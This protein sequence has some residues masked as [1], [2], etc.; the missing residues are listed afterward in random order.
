[1]TYNT[2]G[3]VSYDTFNNELDGYECINDGVVKSYFKKSDYE[4][5][6]R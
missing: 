6:W 3:E 5:D 2:G 1:V 4:S